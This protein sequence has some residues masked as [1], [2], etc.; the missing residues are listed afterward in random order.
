MNRRTALIFMAVSLIFGGVAIWQSWAWN[1][2]GYHEGYTPVQPIAF[3]HAQHAG[4]LEIPCEYCHTAADESRYAAIPPAQTCMTCHSTIA[5]DSEEIA[6]LTR[7]YEEAEPIPWVRVNKLPDHVYFD[8]SR[9]VHGDVACE[10]C[11]GDVATM[12]EVKQAETFSMGWCID[13][14]RETEEAERLPDGSSPRILGAP[15]TDCS[16]CHQ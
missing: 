11:H 15:S 4:E 10:D 7:F 9:H 16:A 13:C 6:K 2:P 3:S 1:W 8:H 14:H 12:T 5:T